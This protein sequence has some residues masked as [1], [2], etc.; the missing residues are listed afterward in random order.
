MDHG[1]LHLGI[2]CTAFVGSHFVL[3]NPLRRPLIRLMGETAFLAVYSLI[4]L[5]ALVWVVFAFDRAAGGA[6]LWDGTALLPWG[7]ASLLT[8][9]GLVLILASLDNN[10]ALP[11][12]NL[13]G[14]SARKPW[15]AFRVTRHPMMFG[16]ALWALGHVLVAPTA[17]GAVLHGSL[18]ALALGGSALQDRRKQAASPREWGVWMARTTF[19]P[20]PREAR[21]LGSAWIAG[22]IVW[23]LLTGGHLYLADI[24][25]GLWRA[26]P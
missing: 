15:G 10:P 7:A 16:I 17:R 5:A 22:A 1:L 4:A 6:P 12:T 20:R 24:P 26:L 25:A 3:S 8:Y 23:V 9:L 18:V 13:A 2:A 11:R 21:A 19:F 14:L